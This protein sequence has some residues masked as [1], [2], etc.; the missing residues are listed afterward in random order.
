MTD[1]H[2]VIADFGIT[3][4]S[5]AAMRLTHTGTVIGTPAYMAPEQLEG[6]PPTPATDLWSLGATLCTALEGR[7]PFTADTFSALCVA[8][9]MQEPP[10]PERAGPL[11]PVMAALLAKEL[12]RRASAGQALATLEAEDRGEA[13]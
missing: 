10:V 2:V 3:H 5:D 4:V 6:K 12:D 13:P 9:V 7:P 1:D 11:A 8:I